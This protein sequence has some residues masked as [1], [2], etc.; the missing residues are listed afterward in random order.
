MKT[1][2]LINKAIVI[3]ALTALCCIAS[4][5]QFSKAGIQT[6]GDGSFGRELRPFDFTDKFYST[7]GVEA[8]LIVNRRNGSDGESVIDFTDDEN[9]SNVRI[10]ATRPGYAYD[11]SPIYWNLYGG[12]FKEAFVPGAAG[13]QAR[14]VAESF[15]VY[16]FPS[17]T[18]KNQDRQAV[19]IENIEGYVDKNPLG[20]G[21]EM[22][23]EYGGAPI[24]RDDAAF[25]ASLAKQNGRSLDGTPIIR[26]K[27][28]LDEL[29]RRNLVTVRTRGG[30]TDTGAP[31]FVIAKII[32][33]PASGA[34][35]PDAFLIMVKGDDGKPLAGEDF[36]L[37]DFECYRG[38]CA[39]EQ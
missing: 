38:G 35:T 1:I 4:F 3:S 33:D 31:T 36:F 14:S 24:N 32:R 7:H 23:V 12:F 15:P 11:G 6:A 30:D 18:A 19:L 9:L 16:V 10:L 29:V 5:A 21:L 27:R 37:H 34:I 2:T 22:V 28:E 17:V 8:A 39:I 20:L 13:D 25:L 26:M